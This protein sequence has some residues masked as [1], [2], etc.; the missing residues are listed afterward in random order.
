VTSQEGGGCGNIPDHRLSV[1]HCSSK[2]DP[3]TRVSIHVEKSKTVQTKESWT[4]EGSYPSE[5]GEFLIDSFKSHVRYVLD[6]AGC[7]R[8]AE[9]KVSFGSGGSFLDDD[10]ETFEAR[11]VLKRRK[12]GGDSMEGQR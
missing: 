1:Q 10:G 6:V 12:T 5:I 4:A 7:R 2:V 8:R 9:D 11:Q 3:I